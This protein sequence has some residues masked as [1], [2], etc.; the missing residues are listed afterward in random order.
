MR[1]RKGQEEK[2]EMR[3]SR[4]GGKRRKGDRGKDRGSD[5]RRREAN[6]YRRDSIVLQYSY[7]V[8]VL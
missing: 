7:L 3:E 8:A 4:T 6:V 1:E 5:I 2:E